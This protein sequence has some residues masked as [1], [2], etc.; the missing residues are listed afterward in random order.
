METESGRNWLIAL[1]YKNEKVAVIDKNQPL[2]HHG[3]PSGIYK[4]TLA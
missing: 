3:E 1:Y 2:C 4:T